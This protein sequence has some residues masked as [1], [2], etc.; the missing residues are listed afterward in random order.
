LKSRSDL[1]LFSGLNFTIAFMYNC[2]DQ[3]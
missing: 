3:A 2:D 1:S